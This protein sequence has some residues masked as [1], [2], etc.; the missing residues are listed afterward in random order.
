MGG[1]SADAARGRERERGGRGG[2]SLSLY[3]SLS[4]SDGMQKYGRMA[5]SGLCKR[6]SVRDWRQRPVHKLSCAAVC[7]ISVLCTSV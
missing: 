7:K 5:T 6:S 4:L 1:K 3:L 2:L